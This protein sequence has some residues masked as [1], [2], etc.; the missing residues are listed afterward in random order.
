MLRLAKQQTYKKCIIVFICLLIVI[1]IEYRTVICLGADGHIDFEPAFN[2][3]CDETDH[4]SA[5]VQIEL[6]A[7]EG[8]EIC[9]HCGSCVDFPIYKDMVQISN[10]PQKLNP[11]FLIPAT[12]VLIDFVKLNSSVY[13]LASNS[14]TDTSY[15][16]PLRTVIL[17]V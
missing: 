4:P 7:K 13:N 9:K 11:V 6:S 14:F 2:E 16:D 12:N 5:S 17:L 8:H 1:N 3:C 10:T 15:F